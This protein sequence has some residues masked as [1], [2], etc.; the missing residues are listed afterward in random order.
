MLKK[1]KNYLKSFWKYYFSQKPKLILTIILS[2]IVYLMIDYDLRIVISS[3]MDKGYSVPGII[4]IL[5]MYKAGIMI[6]LIKPI[7]VFIAGLIII[8][9]I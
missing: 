1:L 5:S 4:K 9:K 8:K 3:Y 7:F 6:L 2:L